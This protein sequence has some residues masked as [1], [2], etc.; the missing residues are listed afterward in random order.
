M[1][2]NVIGSLLNFQKKPEG[3]G[4]ILSL[5]EFEIGL[6]VS[7]SK[8]VG[9]QFAQALNIQSAQFP[10]AMFGCGLYDNDASEGSATAVIAMV[11]VGR[12][13]AEKF[14]ISIWTDVDKQTRIFG[15]S[16]TKLVGWLDLLYDIERDAEGKIIRED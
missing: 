7:E 16:R 15:V 6:T 2:V 10:D 4:C 5:P 8:R 14:I 9:A 1:S 3:E 11:H 12:I 13:T